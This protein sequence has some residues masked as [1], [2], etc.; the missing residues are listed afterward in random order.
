LCQEFRA[1][2][3]GLKTVVADADEAPRQDMKK[4]TMDELGSVEGQE[5]ALIATSAIAIGK[6]DL[7]VRERDQTFIANGNPVGI[8]AKIAKDLFGTGHGW[9]AVDDPFSS[10]RLAEQPAPGRRSRTEIL[11]QELKELST[12][13]PR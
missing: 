4:E 3:V 12:E 7:P 2:A 8:A 9:L 1:A 11:R 6:R 5:A 13:D 10:E